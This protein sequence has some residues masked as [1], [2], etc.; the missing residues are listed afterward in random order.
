MSRDGSHRDCFSRKE[1][2][3]QR[4]S[5]S[6]TTTP[7]VRNTALTKFRIQKEIKMT[8]FT[9]KF[10]VSCICSL[11]VMCALMPMVSAKPHASSGSSATSPK[12]GVNCHLLHVQLHGTQPPTSECLDKAQSNSQFSSVSPNVSRTGCQ[13]GDV[14][15]Y[16]SNNFTGDALCFTGT[17]QAN[18]TD[19]GCGLFCSWNDRASSWWTGSWFVDFYKNTN[20]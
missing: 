18:M 1:V 13:N 17:G 20:R 5:A 9:G 16:D 3:W 7:S 10:V 19:F 15:L 4:I 2:Y 6:V 14:Y 8:R 12:P 11:L